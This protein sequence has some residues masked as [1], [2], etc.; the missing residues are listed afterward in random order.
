VSRHPNIINSNAPISETE[1]VDP[2]FNRWVLFRE[3]V[4]QNAELVD[5]VAAEMF[6][7]GSRN[8]S[9]DGILTVDNA[10]WTEQ[11]QCCYVVLNCSFAMIFKYCVT[12]CVICHAH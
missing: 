2:E 7:G 10:L 8:G 11:V 3:F 6:L 12:L 9:G 4:D 1:K 5:R